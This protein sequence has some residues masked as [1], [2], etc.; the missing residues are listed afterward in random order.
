M[1]LDLFRSIETQLAIGSH[2]GII[3]IAILVGADKEVDVVPQGP[4]DRGALAIEH[5]TRKEVEQVIACAILFL[6]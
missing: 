1:A 3:G 5:S 6:D 2:G 4:P